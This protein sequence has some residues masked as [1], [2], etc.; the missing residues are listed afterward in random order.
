MDQ[1]DGAEQYNPTGED[2]FGADQQQQEDAYNEVYVWGG[3]FL[4]HLFAIRSH[5]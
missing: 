4:T 2:D 3:K 1:E 5:C